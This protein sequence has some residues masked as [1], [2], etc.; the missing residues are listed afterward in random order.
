MRF[1]LLLFKAYQEQDYCDK[2]RIWNQMV[3]IFNVG[4]GALGPN[5]HP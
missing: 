3:Y 5:G 4:L 1:S 2:E